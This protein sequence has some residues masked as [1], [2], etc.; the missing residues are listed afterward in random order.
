MAHGPVPASRGLALN[1]RSRFLMAASRF[2]EPT[3]TKN[4]N[5]GGSVA[6]QLKGAL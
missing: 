5:L 2:V 3:G 4:Q 1:G 6:D